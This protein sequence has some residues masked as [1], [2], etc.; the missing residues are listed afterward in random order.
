M[1][2]LL[3]TTD[4]EAQQQ[5]QQQST[6]TD[7]L[8]SEQ[9]PDE[10]AIMQKRINDKEAFIEQLKQERQQDRDQM[11]QLRKDLESLKKATPTLEEAVN[12]ASPKTSEKQTTEPVDTDELTKLVLAEVDKREKE[13][14]TQAEQQ[15]REEEQKSTYQQTN[16]AIIDQYGE[17]AKDVLNEKLSEL[18]ISKDKAKSMA[19]DPELSKVFLNLVGA[20]PSKSSSVPHSGFNTASTAHTKQNELPRLSK[21][22]SVEIANYMKQLHNKR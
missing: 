15:Q 14:L 6:E 12:R 21:M 8:G 1:T 10:K 22:S 7:L 13:K 19:S 16:Q 9:T 4:Q 11:D 2:D 3:E 17:K 18:G 5:E 20:Q